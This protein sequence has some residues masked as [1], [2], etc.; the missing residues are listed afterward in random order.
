MLSTFSGIGAPEQAL[1]NLNIKHEI[2]AACE[3]DKYAKATYLANHICNRWFDDITKI[4]IDKLEDFDLYV[5]GFPCQSYSSCG[6]RLGLEDFR[7][8]LIYN[9]LKIL[10]NKQP[11]YFIAENVKGLLERDKGENFKTILRL[12]E[13]S[14]YKV[15]WKLLNSR[16]FGISQSRPRLYF[17]GIHNDIV[18]EFNFGNVHEKPQNPIWNI[19]E[20]NPPDNHG[21]YKFKRYLSIN[22][23]YDIN[24]NY[25]GSITSY[26]RA[27]KPGEKRHQKLCLREDNIVNCITRMP[28]DSMIFYKGKLR[29]Y[30]ELE[31]KRLQGFP[32]DFKFPV[33]Y[34]EVQKQIGNTMTIP[35]LEEIF[36]ELLV[37]YLSVD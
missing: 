14:G 15:V 22:K 9:S 29:V 24:K 6:K 31:L 30:T 7:G 5:L 12:F 1:K 11:K 37:D 23:P 28:S 33:K 32:A 34:K 8:Q 21:C 26:P 18:Q 20:E 3:I 13:E 2:T 27:L 36:K 10:Q 19:L 17:I 25:T 16:N 35:V 4:D